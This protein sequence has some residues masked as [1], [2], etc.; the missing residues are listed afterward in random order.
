[1]GMVNGKP[2]QLINRKIKRP[3]TS[4]S[5]MFIT[6]ASENKSLIHTKHLRNN[7]N[8]TKTTANTEFS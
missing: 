1:M 3:T 2:L 7:V 6:Q 5:E 4:A 8:T